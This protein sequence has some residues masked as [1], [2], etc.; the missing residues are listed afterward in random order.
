VEDDEIIIR[1]SESMKHS[2]MQDDSCF[3]V[4]I[5][6]EC[7]GD[8]V[9]E[10]FIETLWD[11]QLILEDEAKEVEQSTQE[12]MAY[13]EDSKDTPGPE[14]FEVI[15][16]SCL[17]K[18]KPSSEDLQELELKE[19]PNHLEY[20]SFA[21]GDKLPMIIAR[22]LD[23]EQKSQLVQVLKRHK[24]GLAWNITDTKG[25]SCHSRDF[26]MLV[27]RMTGKGKIS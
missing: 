21:Q 13:M 10:H 4:D 8:F 12:L 19:L 1:I 27:G 7:I 26:C 25:I 3:M 2:S 24:K 5:L 11:A 18:M 23:K 6:N 20:A 16:K 14:V 22:D 9:Q 17:G 15:E